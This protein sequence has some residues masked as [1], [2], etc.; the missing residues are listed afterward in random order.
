[1]LIKFNEFQIYSLYFGFFFISYYLMLQFFDGIHVYIQITFYLL[2]SYFFHHPVQLSVIALDLS[3][4]E[5]FSIRIYL[6]LT[7]NLS[8]KMV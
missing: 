1:M 7:Q 8:L 3:R 4:K 2:S 6:G 5:I